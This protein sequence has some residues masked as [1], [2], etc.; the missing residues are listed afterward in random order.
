MTAPSL[1]APPADLS[2]VQDR[3]EAVLRHFLG[4]KIRTAVEG[5]LPDDVP[6]ALHGFLH[7]G[8]KR[9]SP[10][11]CVVGWQAAG[12]HGDSA[13][14]ARVAAGLELFHAFCLIHDDNMDNSA[15]RRRR[16]AVHR[17][18]A[19]RHPAPDSEDAAWWGI[20][21]AILA[22]DMALAWSQELLDTTVSPPARRA[23]LN[24]VLQ[25]MRQEVTYGQHLDLLAPH[26]PATDL[27]TTLRVIRYKTAKY[28][29]ERPLHTG[30]VLAGADQGLLDALSRY[31]LPLGEAFQLRDDVLGIYGTPK[32]TG[33]PVLDDL[34]EGKHTVLLALAAQRATPTQRALLDRLVGQRALDEAGAARIRQVL[35]ATGAR[36]TVEAMIATRY[37]QALAALQNTPC[38]PVSITA[39]RRIAA[40]AVERTS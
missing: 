5:C 16:P 1:A 25:T 37:Q 22:G 28:T 39:L 9:L 19:H 4:Q 38:P 14:V 8:G 15:T 17:A 40:L 24:Q 23:A 20:C 10:L 13:P 6:R 32:Q 26:K 12:G 27:D 36:S 34:R 11:L 18:L 29:V 7:A 35:E 33:K 21:G 31:A 30:A 3:V 2:A